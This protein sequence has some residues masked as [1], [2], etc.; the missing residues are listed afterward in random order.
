[1][2]KLSLPIKSNKAPIER[3]ES[4]RLGQSVRLKRV[5]YQAK[6]RIYKDKLKRLSKTLKTLTLSINVEETQNRIKSSKCWFLTM[7][8]CAQ[9][10]HNWEIISLR[11]F[12]SNVWLVYDVFDSKN[13]KNDVQYADNDI[14]DPSTAVVLTSK[15]WPTSK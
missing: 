3:K 7:L 13:W 14:Y 5:F 1:M 12:Y 8:S 2:C 9:L 15:Q 11:T 4:L 6:S 10:D